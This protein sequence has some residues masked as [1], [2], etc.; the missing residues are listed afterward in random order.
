M[1][2]SELGSELLV[3]TAQRIQVGLPSFFQST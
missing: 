2:L 3:L 1:E